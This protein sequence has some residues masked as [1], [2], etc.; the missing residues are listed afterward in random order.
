ML[1][2]VE[3]MDKGESREIS[4]HDAS[5]NEDVCWTETTVNNDWETNMVNLGS[6]FAL[7]TG[8]G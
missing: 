6:P 1:H 7:S 3:N 5:N 8:I 2:I 4:E